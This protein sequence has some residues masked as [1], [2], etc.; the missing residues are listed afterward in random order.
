MCTG[1]NPSGVQGFTSFNVIGTDTCLQDDRSQDYLQWSSMTGDYLFTHCGGV[2]STPPFTMEGKG[3]PGLVNYTRTLND[4][5]TDRKITVLYLTNQFTGH[6]N[7]SII[8]GPGL[9]QNYFLNQ[10]N[11]HPTCVCP[12]ATAALVE[13]ALEDRTTR[14]APRRGPS[15]G[16]AVAQTV[17]LR[18]SLPSLIRLA[19]QVAQTAAWEQG[20]PL[21]KTWLREP[22]SRQGLG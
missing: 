16:A 2:G 12:Q 13:P 4:A 14:E 22:H 9:S 17:S 18:P 7:V 11:P 3:V 19:R 20:G 6:G 15:P 21:P 8:L 1:T 10:T 5:Q